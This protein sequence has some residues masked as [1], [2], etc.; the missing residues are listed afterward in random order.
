MVEPSCTP[1][2]GAAV[3]TEG[4]SRPV[5]V[6]SATD[7]ARAAADW[8]GRIGVDTEFQRTNTFFPIPGLYQIAAGADV[9]LV[10]PL[11]IGDWSPLIDVLRDPATVKVL[12][13]CSEDLELFHCHLGVQPQA[14]FDTQLAF[15]FL[16]T[17]FSLSYAALLEKLLGVRLAKHHTRSNWLRRPLSAEQLHYARED[18][19]FL[20][21]M[22]GSLE[23]RLRA[24]GR[25]PWF[26]EEMQR[27]GCYKPREPATYFTGVKRAWQLDGTQLAV[28]QA[29]CEWRE[30]CAMA[31]D[32]PRNRIVWD[33]HLLEFAQRGQLDMRALRRVLPAG[34]ARRYGEALMRAHGEGLKAPPQAPIPRPISQ[35]KGGLFKVLRALGRERAQV[36][37]M[38][39][40]L[41]ARPRD[42]ERCIR[43]HQATGALSDT[44]LGWRKP[45][46]G[47]AFLAVLEDCA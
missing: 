26:L 36:L 3:S 10:D 24:V 34:I 32:M 46:L 13:A 12:H 42:I 1:C 20:V 35:K 6:D 22:Q 11:A 37:G 5:W 27:N 41:L 44:Y 38:A 29:L 9:W 33:E 47:D 19:A 7:L 43:H 4:T 18:V 21:D 30:R 14:V 17:D 31:E 15:A 45:L 2:R 39:A 25:W 16:S 28:L 8:C 40:E 23:A